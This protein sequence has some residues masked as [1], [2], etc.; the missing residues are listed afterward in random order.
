MA[1]RIDARHP[2]T[3]ISGRGSM[4]FEVRLVSG[5]SG[6]A[7]RSSMVF[8]QRGGLD[9]AVQHGSAWSACASAGRSQRGP[10]VVPA[11]YTTK[12]LSSRAPRHGL[13]VSSRPL[14]LVRRE[15]S[16]EPQPWAEPSR[17]SPNTCFTSVFA[18]HVTSTSR[19]S[20]HVTYVTLPTP[21]TQPSL[22]AVTLSGP[23][24]CW[25]SEE[26]V[27]TGSQLTQTS[28]GRTGLDHSRSPALPG[29]CGFSLI[30]QRDT[31]V[32]PTDTRR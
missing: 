21:S 6:S 2:L 15:P 22:P 18:A 1:H 8:A 12:T 32:D 24:L 3:L 17:V 27:R 7:S 4:P 11:P 25:C 9:G 31:A 29:W 13:S 30:R 23:T 26:T 16:R 5:W 19:T 14:W 20:R 28:H 10:G